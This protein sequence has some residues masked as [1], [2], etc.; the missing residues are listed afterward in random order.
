M[1]RGREREGKASAPASRRVADGSFGGDMNSLGPKFPQQAPNTVFR[2]RRKPY[3]W[4]GRT[5]IRRKSLGSDEL[6]FMPKFLQMVSGL[7][8]RSDYSVDLR[9]PRIRCN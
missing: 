7:P 3:S 6:Y 9:M 4:I 5:R 2:K 8:K 1:V